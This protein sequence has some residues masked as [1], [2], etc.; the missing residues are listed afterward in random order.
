MFEKILVCLDSSQLSEEILPFAEEQ[1]RRFGSSIILLQVITTHITI[2]P[3]GVGYVFPPVRAAG[4]GSSA[5]AESNRS[6][7]EKEL[8]EVE[9]ED[10][11]ATAYLAGV[12]RRL[13]EKGIDAEI[14]T[15]QGQPG[16]AIVSYAEN[17][18]ISLIAIATHGRS[19][20][21]RTVIGSVADYVLRESNLPVLMVKPGEGE[22]KPV[23]SLFK[24]ILVCLDGSHLAEQI[25]PYAV[26]EARR[27]GGT[28]VLLRVI[29]KQ[30][31]YSANVPGA[32][33][34]PVWIPGGEQELNKEQNRAKQY[35]L[36]KA[37]EI[38]QT[39][40]GTVQMAVISGPAAESI[41]DYIAKNEIDLVTFATHGR[42]GLERAL[43]GSVTDHVLRESGIPA[44]VVKP[45]DQ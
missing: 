28:I 44:I 40:P 39:M 4:P 42:N 19:G 32:S 2:P 15:V 11:Q 1:A 16:E 14:V 34:V 30:V 20:L 21:Q 10:N 6:L 25:V 7:A 12:A 37:E 35:L 13:R 23:K 17:N 33:G 43:I 45:E 29:H 22:E 27:F 31:Q 26:E 38:A 8:I 3:A 5:A 36:M 41:V 9:R 18:G 24:R